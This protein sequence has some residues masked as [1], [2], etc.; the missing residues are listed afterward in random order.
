M[1]GAPYRCAMFEARFQSFEDRREPTASR[2]RVNALRT[3]LARR[4]LTGFVIPHADRQQNEYVPASEQR[5]AWLTGFSGSAGTAIV[6]MERAVLF[7]DGRYTLQAR[8]QVDTSLFTIEH[9]VDTPPERWI[10]HNLGSSDRIGARLGPRLYVVLLG[11]LSLVA[12]FLPLADHLGYELSELIAFAAGLFGAV[13]GIAA[14]RLERESAGRALSRALWFSLQALAIPLAVILL[15][16]LRR[17]VCDPLGGLAMYLALAAPS[18]V[19]SCTLGVACGF[20]AP[21]WAGWLYAALFAG[22]LLVALWPLVFGPQVFAFHHLGGMYPGPIYDE[23]IA[24]SRALWLFRA[25]TLLYAGACA[26]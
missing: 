22:S 23:A 20:L 19:L 17:P 16:G 5:L 24:T 18:A 13:P 14:A 7:V 25:D 15:N 21:R 10:E 12:C 8:E 11:F 1:A 4:N 6:L 9:L 3:E 2:P 26:S